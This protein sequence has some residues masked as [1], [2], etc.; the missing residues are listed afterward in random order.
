MFNQFLKS[1]DNVL[2]T[3]RSAPEVSQKEYLSI[4]T[5]IEDYVKENNLIV[6][7][8]EIFIKKKTTGI[9]TY[10]IYGDDIFK[11]AN[12][13]SNEISRITIYVLMHTN[14]KNED[15]VIKVNGQ[16]MINLFNIPKK[17]KQLVSPI[18]VCDMLV[19]PPEF[20]LINVYHKLYSPHHAGEWDDLVELEETLKKH[21]YERQDIIGGTEI[22]VKPFH[23]NFIDNQLI[24]NWLK[25]RRDYVLVGINAIAALN[26]FEDPYFQKI[27]IITS[28]D[29]HKIVSELDNILFQFT[30]HRCLHKTH[31]SNIHIEPRM[32]KTIISIKI[33]K[34]TIHLIDIF[35]NAQFELVPYTTYDGLEIGY[36]NV[37]RMFMLVDMWFLRTLY[38]LEVI[39]D[40]VLKRGVCDI[41]KYIK[42]I[43]GLDPSCYDSE[44]YLGVYIDLNRHKQKEAL[45]NIYYPYIPEQAR[46]SKGSYRTIQ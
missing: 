6:S 14:K 34:R 15:F 32:T 37:L 19:Y 20:E 29:I 24:L 4:Y 41:L 3:A 10:T 1:F 2:E 21:M 42:V 43:D 46:Y 38:A 25:G 7:S 22:S 17:L 44:N 27:Q 39:T 45:G 11:H 26:N 16:S 30:G 23:D 9:K 28:S 12:T 5:T 31:S 18:R 8:P 33:K 36:P 40:S 35:N 13:L